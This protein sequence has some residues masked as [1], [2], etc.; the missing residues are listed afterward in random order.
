MLNEVEMAKASAN[1]PFMEHA[2]RE[3]HKGFT[4]MTLACPKCKSVLDCTRSVNVTIELT[5]LDDKKEVLYS[6][7]TCANCWDTTVK[8][9][10]ENTEKTL[11]A[12]FVPAKGKALTVSFVDGRELW[13]ARKPRKTKMK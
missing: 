11:T 13:P 12:K 1:W 2:M 4:G 3:A 8:A 6:I 9:N 7:I 10:A 5:K